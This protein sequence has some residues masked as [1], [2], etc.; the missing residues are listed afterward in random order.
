[1]YINI[2]KL[3]RVRQTLLVD[4]FL[5]FFL[6]SRFFCLSSSKINDICKAIEKECYFSLLLAILFHF[7]LKNN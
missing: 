6:L 4:F 2:S 1:M 7:F 3:F 5:L